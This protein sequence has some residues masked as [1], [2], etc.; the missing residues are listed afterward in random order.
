MFTQPKNPF[1]LVSSISA[2]LTL[3]L[4][5]NRAQAQSTGIFSNSGALGTADQTANVGLSTTKTYLEAIDLGDAVN[6]TV[7]GILFT[8]SG[9]AVAPSGAGWALTGTVNLFGGGG[10]LPGGVLGG[11]T[12]KFVYGGIPATMTLTGLTVG[13]TYVITFYDRSWEG[14]GNR[15]E[16]L[17]ASGA[18]SASTTFDLD[19]GATGQGNLN[20]LRYTFQAASATQALTIAPQNPGNTMHLYAFT[21]EQT[22]NNSWTSGTDWTTSAWSGGAPNSVGAN[23]SFAAQAAPR[24]INLD[25]AQTVGHMQFD[26]ANAWTL[27]GA[28]TLTLQTDVGGVSV[29]STLAG[30]HTISTAIALGTD[31]VKLGGGALTLSGAI[32]GTRGLSVNG[33]LLNLTTA[34]S[35]SG[36]TAV[37]SGGKLRI[38]VD[39]ALG[40]T[41]APLTVNTGGTLDLNGTSP[42]V[43]VLAGT[44]GII[45]NDLSA[46][47]STLSIG[48]G[49]T[50]G[51]SST[52]LAD[53]TTGTGILALTKTGTA[54]ATLSGANTYTGLTSIANGRLQLNGSAAAGTLTTS[55]IN[56]SAT[57]T[58]GFTGNVGSTLTLKTGSTLT[59][60][61]G[62][63]AIDLGPVANTDKIV[64]DTFSLTANSSLA[65]NAI[66]PPS[67][68]V[69]YTIATYNTLN[70][71]GAFTIS[72]LAVGRL[73]LN[74]TVGANAITL[75]P[76]LDSSSWNSPTSGAWTTGPWTSYTPNA[77]GDSAVLGSALTSAGTI[78][79][80][81]AKTV[82]FL[83]FN[84]SAAAYTLG[85]AGSNNLTLSN[86]TSSAVVYVNG[87]SH[88]IAENVAL[89]S[90]VAVSVDP[91][92][93]LVIKGVISGARALGKFGTGT[94]TLTN[95]NTYSG[96]TTIAEGTLQLG[97]GATNGAIA[98]NV[99][100]NGTLAINSVTAQTLAAAMS[101]TG[102]V[103][104]TGNA[105][106]T[107]TGASTST[108]GMTISAGTVDIGGNTAN[109]AFTGTIVNNATLR[110]SRTGSYII[111]A[112]VNGTGNTI[113]SGGVSAGTATILGATASIN[114]PT[115]IIGDAGTTQGW[116]NF[117][118]PNQLNG[119]TG[120]LLTIS[121]HANNS[122]INLSGFNETI[123]GLQGTGIVQT[124]ETG[125]FPA[126]TLT[127]N[128]PGTN[129]YNWTGLIRNQAAGALSLTKTGT[130]EQIMN[131]QITNP[132]Y[133][134][135]TTVSQ[136]RLIF[137][138]T[139]AAPTWSTSGIA[140]AAGTEVGLTGSGAGVISWSEGVAI[141]G[142]GSLVRTG[143]D[144]N[145]VTITNA[146]N[147]FTG[148]TK[149]SGTGTL[150]IASLANIGANSAIGAGTG[151][152]NSTNA[153]SLVFDG[154]IL[155]YTGAAVAS[156]RLFT[157]TQN[158]GTFDASG[159]GA[160]NFN[161]PGPL[162]TSGSGA[163]TLVLTGTNTGNNTLAGALG[164]GAGGATSV[165]K[166]LAG[167][168]ALSG[169]STY[170][171]PTT[172]NAGRLQFE[173]S[174]AT[175]PRTTS[176]LLV[177]A[178]AT[179]GFSAGSASTLAL[180]GILTL[181]GG[182]AVLDLGGTGTSDKITANT[183]ALTANSAFTFNQI[184]GYNVG[185]NYT[186]VSYAT[187]NNPGGFTV[188]GFS[189]GRLTLNPVIGP[190]A[191]TMTPQLDSAT[192]NTAAGGNWETG[193]WL[194]Y[195]PNAVGD[196]ALFGNK[197]TASDVVA[198]NLPETVG[199]LTFDNAAASYTLGTSFSSNLTLANSSTAV[200]QVIVNAGSH[201]IAENVNL[202][203]DLSVLTAAST[204][205]NILGTI[206]G[207]PN[208]VSKN[209]PGTLRL[210]GFNSF[211]TGAG[212]G[213]NI[214][215]GN[216]VLDNLG[217]L[218]PNT[219][220]NLSSGILNL[221]GYDTSIGS[222]A[223]NGGTITDT[224]ATPGPTVLT[225]NQAA[226][227]TFGGVITDGAART[228]SFVK[229]GAGTLTLGG[230]NT[231]SGGF[232]LVAG[233]INL[234]SSGIPIPGNITM[235]DGTG[236]AI[237]LISGA[238]TQQFGANTVVTFSNAGTDAKLELR[239]T[240]QTLAGVDSTTGQNLSI[241]QNDE[242]TAPGFTVA[243]GEAT[244]ILNTAT[245]HSFYGII[246]NQ[247]GG[248]LSFVKNGPGTQEFINN[249]TVGSFNYTGT[250][251]INAGKLV[252]NLS[253]ATAAG[254]A[255]DI[256]V[257]SPGTLGL[258]GTWT[259]AR[260]VSGAGNVVKQGFGTVTISSAL[261]YT[262][263]TTVAA[264]TL[265]LTG[266]ISG[267]P[268]IDIQTG[269]ILDVGGVGGGY[270]FG[271]TQTL[272]GNGALSG[273]ATI[274]GTLAPGSSL[275]TLTT[276]ALTLGGN[277]VFALE[278]DTSD[279]LGLSGSSDLAAVNGALTLNT[280]I[281]PKLTISDLGSNVPLAP[282]TQFTFITYTVGWNGG[283]F[284][285]GGNLI[286]DD[287]VFAFGANQFQLDYNSGGNSVA[288]IAVPEPCAAVLLLGG[289][290]LL[291]GPRRRR[292]AK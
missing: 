38:S 143:A 204:T 148:A 25:A 172:I 115:L 80:D 102:G 119:T 258:D 266:S 237:W 73:S 156:N 29:L 62:A 206:N 147:S 117:S 267:S 251:T 55:G 152:N 154:G 20:L 49:D 246:R 231:F 218:D 185:T 229:K 91:S 45:A 203:S 93:A 252:L 104:K 58:L 66:A 149:L 153:A 264:G 59:L 24:T 100:N 219:N 290:A 270:T 21:N 162:V 274:N 263:N 240:V 131:F 19:T 60:G 26:G 169:A 242:A 197:L 44:G 122:R 97:D 33:G 178:G 52:A 56:I 3:S 286:P 292:A 291:G 129:S 288:L 198:L 108:G 250:T 11:L 35:Y 103:T 41:N 273:A 238:P 146:T 34:N 92:A 194:A 14:A 179:L 75:T 164:D 205:L 150:S 127:I 171:G 111:T 51:S 81:S 271:A 160:V 39:G 228:V 47:T 95:A 193:P 279:V 167:T 27:S 248:G 177:N 133:T 2:A 86:G 43:G 199:Y 239:G 76:V 244:L 210:G 212:T 255:S 223:G 42:S 168:W 65:F 7:N 151:T 243:P 16:D 276:S 107:L 275:G 261:T 110:F 180:A 12:D 17:T 175:T 130:G 30:S 125:T 253:G 48:T 158:G 109:G 72:G 265:A 163:R 278:I 142:A 191:I 257:N 116:L 232:K 256:T 170:T 145:T 209:G 105:T 118:A 287:G 140:V 211:G 36:G 186:L 217:T 101:G 138:S 4:V 249:P 207:F 216:V 281:A 161:N 254:Y 37:N 165:T 123:S 15:L 227:A 40:A 182:T 222:L 139:L 94:L 77:I 195:T 283:L 200:A 114:T 190:T 87:G 269:A 226:N 189:A 71:P 155:R 268:N 96:G 28:N 22:F 57:G 31:A 272:R 208:S 157:L 132:T 233:S 230:A 201:T 106:L 174:A 126:N 69:L 32:S 260:A 128:V 282:G 1:I 68:G 90:N 74:P 64:A 10:A 13:Q 213:L 277:S 136:G 83:T 124:G 5:G 262:G 54:T 183:L 79:L 215:Q 235:G 63:L 245:D 202:A 284:S 61:G 53:H 89:A 220:V 176:N 121:Q 224:N 113:V 84:N 112:V 144:A 280:G 46:T 135:A 8:G 241:I 50:G 120:V 159:T 141:S 78:T 196:A 285:V 236:G 221:N 187:L 259:L 18:S 99:V 9:A 134:G 137:G 166:N 289:V 247:S 88:T 85:T 173:G 225:V 23:A 70:N 192:W 184:G 188:S 234:A 98:G 82:G 6:T 181:S 214:N 67:I